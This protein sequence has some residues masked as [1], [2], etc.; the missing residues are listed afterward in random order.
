MSFEIDRVVKP[1]EKM[2]ANRVYLLH[3][4]SVKSRNKMRDPLVFLESVKKQLERKGIEVVTRE[5]DISD[6]LPLLST[7]S[8]IIVK[9]KKE[10][11]LVYVN[12]SAS[13]K[14]TAVA[15][16]LAAM[17]HDVKVYYVPTVATGYALDEKEILK[18]GISVVDDPKCLILTNF[19]I[20]MP[21]GAKSTFLVELYEK[22]RMTTNDIMGMIRENKL[23]GFEDLNERIRGKQ[24]TPSNMLVR[25]NR[26]LLDELERNGYIQIEKKGRHKIVVITD[27][28]KYAAC[29]IGHE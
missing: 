11:N 16:T 22:G 14:L 29:L 13:G 6:P 20:D 3:Y 27:K 25:I 7:I 5:S 28:G 23:K 1:F 12:M 26:G 10:K 2:K 18:H 15:S 9:E 17:Y 24:R 19:N 4:K 8:N 21:A